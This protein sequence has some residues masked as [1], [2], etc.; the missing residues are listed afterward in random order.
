MKSIKEIALRVAAKRG[1]NLDMYDDQVVAFA[2]ALIAELQKQNEPVGYIRPKDL[3]SESAVISDIKPFSDWIPLFTFPQ[4]AEQIEQRVAEACADFYQGNL[5][6]G[7][8]F[9][10]KRMRSGEWRKFLKGE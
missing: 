2:E 8:P 10:A 5:N 1:I 3:G 4:S 7:V 6:N 9:I